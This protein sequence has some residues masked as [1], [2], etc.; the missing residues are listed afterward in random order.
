MIQESLIDQSSE[1][2]FEDELIGLDE[3]VSD[4]LVSYT[5]PKKI[6]DLSIEVMFEDE[7]KFIGNYIVATL[8]ILC[9]NNKFMR[10]KCE[11][12]RTRR[13]RK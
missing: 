6:V 4:A 2:L 11:K 13:W 1:N 3:S 10:E 12:Q 5:P 8:I 9:D 7:L